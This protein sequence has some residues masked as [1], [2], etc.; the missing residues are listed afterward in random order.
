MAP[1]GHIGPAGKTGR[2]VAGI[3]GTGTWL[4]ECRCLDAKLFEL[5]VL[6]AVSG[7][8]SEQFPSQAQVI[9]AREAAEGLQLG[10]WRFF[11]Q[12]AAGA[13]KASNSGSP[14]VK[15]KEVAET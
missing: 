11:R 6:P 2:V 15:A 4:E 3:K 13:N 14:R 8:P 12:S 9:I 1:K 5:P 10:Y 7:H